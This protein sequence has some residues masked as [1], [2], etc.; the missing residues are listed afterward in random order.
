[1]RKK[2]VFC[3]L[4]ILL[5][6]FFFTL[7]NSKAQVWSDKMKDSSHQKNMVTVID[8]DGKKVTV[9]CCPQR[10]VVLAHYTAEMIK[11]LQEERRV[12]GIDEYTKTKTKWPDYVLQVPSIGQAS[13]FDLEKIISLQPDLV[14]GWQ[15]KPEWREKLKQAGIAYVCIYGYKV[16]KLP[17]EI[18]IL[19]QIFNQEEKA[20]EYADFIEAHWQNVRN[21]V[22]DL[23]YD[24]KPKVYWES[25]LGD[26]STFGENSGAGPLI[27][28]AGGI[29]IVG[30]GSVNNPKVSAEWVLAKNPD[31]IIK[32]VGRNMTGWNGT[33]L[34]K[35]QQLRQEIMSRPSLKQTNA[36][37]NGR[38]YLVFDAIT[39]APRGAAG[40]YYLAKWFHPDLFQDINPQEIHKEMLKRFY[41]QDL[42]GV[43]VYP[44]K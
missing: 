39:C 41:K 44:E 37:K 14:V 40:I 27:K 35:I 1:M 31:V 33:D 13:N 29:N 6:S 10:V 5:F 7:A 22:R 4:A 18:R 26:Y 43:W 23:P 16:K 36:V 8:S 2:L 11:G 25:S 3:L 24:K 19:G 28:W 12:V 15:L 21:R 9:K 42:H 30:E 38:V 20:K 32:Y 17:S 34:E